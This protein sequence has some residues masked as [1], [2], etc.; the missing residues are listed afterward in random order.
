MNNDCNIK[1]LCPEEAALILRCNP[2]DLIPIACDKCSLIH[3]Y[4]GTA[5]KWE[6]TNNIR[7][8]VEDKETNEI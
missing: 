2:E 5:L 1:V 8:L 3:S 4:K 6:T 7:Y